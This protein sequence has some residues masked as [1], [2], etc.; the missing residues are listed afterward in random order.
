MSLSDG[1]KLIIISGPAGAGKTSLAQQ[2]EDGWPSVSKVVSYTTR[3]RRPG[4]VDGVDYHF[5]AREEFDAMVMNASG[6]L[7]VTYVADQKYGISEVSIDDIFRS[8]KVPVLVVDPLGGLRIAQ[9]RDS[10]TIFL[11]ENDPEVLR[12]R[13]TA[14]GDPPQA[15][16]SRIASH[17]VDMRYGADY[18]YIISGQSISHTVSAAYSILQCEL[19]MGQG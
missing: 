5:I 16:Q 4:E 11:A 7:D 2:L 14:R 8:G 19:G 1:A 12:A 13:M 17:E 6:M 3:L 15:I 9:K 10:I 18:M